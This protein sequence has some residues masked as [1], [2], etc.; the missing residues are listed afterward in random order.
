[1]DLI[2]IIASIVCPPLGVFLRVGFK[3]HFWINIVLTLF[4]YIPGLVHAI[5]ILAQASENR[6]VYE[7]HLIRP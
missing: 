6:I 1:M 2:R 5:W 4:G 3:A 7:A